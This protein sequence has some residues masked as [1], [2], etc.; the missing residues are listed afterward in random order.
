MTRPLAGLLLDISRIMRT[1]T[2]VKTH[3]AV[4]CREVHQ[5]CGLYNDNAADRPRPLHDPPGCRHLPR[6]PTHFPLQKRCGA[7]EPTRTYSLGDTI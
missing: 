1:K 3:E 7:R 5:L 6:S 4:S 2:N